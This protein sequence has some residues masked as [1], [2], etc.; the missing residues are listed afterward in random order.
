ML[1]V[2]A[3]HFSFLEVYSLVTSL[4]G[5]S[6]MLIVIQPQRSRTSCGKRELLR[7]LCRRGGGGQGRPFWY[8]KNNNHGLGFTWSMQ[9]E[10]KGN[11]PMRHLLSYFVGISSQTTCAHFTYTPLLLPR[12]QP[13][14]KISHFG[15]LAEQCHHH[16]LGHIIVLG[17]S[18]WQLGLICYRWQGT[19][20]KSTRVIGFNGGRRIDLAAHVR[21]VQVGHGILL[22]HLNVSQWAK[23]QNV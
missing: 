4:H 8:L 20:K 21:W 2:F 9:Q 6:H 15:K 10:Y 19:P 1:Y 17:P 3:L 22:P 13:A 5:L 12:S 18:D 14:V 23:I 11:L 16:S 7:R